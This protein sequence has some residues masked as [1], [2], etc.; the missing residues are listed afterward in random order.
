MRARVSPTRPTAIEAATAAP[1]FPGMSR[2][3][4]VEVT[5]DADVPRQALPLVVQLSEFAQFD[6]AQR[7]PTAEEKRHALV[8]S[9]PRIEKL[10]VV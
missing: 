10:A 6:V 4:R 1:P 9:M 8:T 3:E 2:S 5:E 7:R